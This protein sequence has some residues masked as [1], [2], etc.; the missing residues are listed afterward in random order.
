MLQSPVAIP[1]GKAAPAC[2]Y[3]YRDARRG[4]VDGAEPLS[5]WAD[6]SGLP[7]V[8]ESDILY[9]LNEKWYGPSED[10][11]SETGNS[12]R[13]TDSSLASTSSYQ[14]ADSSGSSSSESRSRYWHSSGSSDSSAQAHSSP[15]PGSGYS[16]LAA[17][18]AHK[19]STPDR[20]LSSAQKPVSTK[21]VHASTPASEST[22]RN[23][24]PKAFVHRWSPDGKHFAQ[25]YTPP[26]SSL[27]GSLGTWTQ[28]MTLFSSQR[29]QPLSP[30]VSP[31]KHEAS[32]PHEVPLRRKQSQQPRASPRGSPQGSPGSWNK[33]SSLPRRTSNHDAPAASAPVNAR[34]PAELMQP[35]GSH[36]TSED[37]EDQNQAAWR[38][39]FNR[40]WAREQARQFQP[41]A[42]EPDD[43]DDSNWDDAL[44][45]MDACGRPGWHLQISRT[46]ST[47]GMLS[48]QSEAGTMLL[49]G[50]APEEGG[51]SSEATRKVVAMARRAQHLQQQ[52]L[53]LECQAEQRWSG[54]APA[55][56]WVGSSMPAVRADHFGRYVFVLA[57]VA[58]C[59]A[60][61]GPPS[62]RK[63]PQKLVL[64]GKAGLSEG[65]LMDALNQEVVQ[66]MAAHSLPRV[67][68]SLLG[69]GTLSW[70][71]AQDLGVRILPGRII[72]HQD[73][74]VSTVASL[75]QLASELLRTS[76]PPHIQV[77]VGE[78]S[79]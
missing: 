19:S 78:L 4:S 25:V 44:G 14:P 77:T 63:Q 20:A 31:A 57:R 8:P 46:A 41:Q 47:E 73:K 54:V 26:K 39:R 37:D 51:K 65:R 48:Q 6:G 42:T 17:R 72:S 3:A 15:S 9:L 1:N 43:D 59:A 38:W 52:Q 40:R 69:S 7:Q 60:H 53:L 16:S 11:D 12:Q 32:S 23:G 50:S 35:F 27:L 58:P 62:S 33:C 79:L 21:S 64:R 18:R 75:A 76:L 28:R 61:T 68:L 2:S 10:E 70:G 56:A 66:A 29:K 22:H 55:P 71:R 30:V 34:A 13:L 36:Q 49:E 67:A 24:A 45:Y 74:D 5:A